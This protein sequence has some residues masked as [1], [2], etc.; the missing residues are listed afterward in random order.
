MFSQKFVFLMLSALL[1]SGICVAQDEVQGDL[2]SN[3]EDFLHYSM[4]G[5]IEMARGYA[6]NILNSDPDPLKLLGFVEENPRGYELLLRMN[7]TSEQLGEVS[8]ALID[9]IEEGRYIRRTDPSIIR[10][11]I[12]RLSSTIRGR[13]AAEERLANAGEY[14]IPFIVEALLDESRKREY[15][16][17]ANAIPKIGRHAIR[18]LAA[19]LEM[20]DVGI[21]SILIKAMGQ[22]GY[23]QSLAY[24]KYIVEN[25]DSAELSST[26]ESAIKSISRDALDLPASE[27]FY[28]LA[29]RYYYHNESLA[30]MV[31]YD[32]ANIWFWDSDEKRLVREQVDL[33]V[34]NE[35]MAMRCCEW[36][37]RADSSAGKAIGLWIASFFK[38]ESA[39]LEQ[40]DYF[41]S[42]HA[43]AMTYAVTA[44]AEYLHQALER[45][46][47]DE[48]DYVALMVV[49]AL[50]ANAG[51]KSLL[52]RLGTEQP[53]VKALDYKD[54]SVRYSAAIAIGGA[55]PNEQ[56]VGSKLI[57]E[58]LSSAVSRDGLSD[59]GQDAIDI[60]AR[61]SLNVMLELAITK[62]KVVDLR[63]AL[64]SLV[65][66]SRDERDFV[67]T[68]SGAVLAR[69]ASP[70]AQRGV[71]LMGMDDDNTKEVRL[72]G[73]KSLA[74]SAKHN[75]NLL[76]EEQVNSL[77]EM[78]SSQTIDSD[79]RES[80]AIAYGS[81]NLPSR[82]VKDLILD[83]AVKSL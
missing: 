32:F 62:N 36:A 47:N 75:G 43:D 48:N 24:L 6:E 50:S 25:S 28:Q 58:N 55:L 1:F 82:K 40:P 79:L 17:I 37:L 2:E 13:I 22:T 5:R 80:A 7:S 74:I 21:E 41:I 15:A 23:P 71:A 3:W 30:P 52:Y 64:D 14:S 66:G 72:S 10:E 56:F 65:S 16:N 83:Q 33:A 4:I 34:F 19:A 39:G 27:L 9:L 20:E 51:E 29:E 63:M 31:G 54:R 57:V 73:L 70:D 8:G 26:A 60:Y 46:L 81:L 78:V 61:R 59:L 44:G 67:K 45:A 35:L 68:M 11:Q 18:P 49:E 38:A 77:Y 42:G 69:L 12:S 53:L 76:T